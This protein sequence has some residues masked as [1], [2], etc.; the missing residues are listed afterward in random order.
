MKKLVIEKAAIAK[1]IAVIKEKAGE[2]TLYGVLTGDGHGGGLLELA[3]MLRDAGIT[4]FAVT[5][6][7]DAAALR[8]AGF[9]SEEL[10][11]L[12]SV[13]NREELET[14][15]DLNVVFTIGSSEAGMALN[16][17]AEGRATVVEA[18]IE[19]DTGMGLGG[20]LPE[21]PDKIFAI[22]E[23]L[24]NV[25]VSGIFTETRS[26]SEKMAEVQLAAFRAVLD[27]IH[28]K[29]FETGCVHAAGS[30]AL[31]HYGIT[32]MEA[33]RVG[34]ALLG[35]CRRTRDDKLKKV[36]YGEVSVEEIRWLPRGHTVGSERVTTLGKATRV[37]VLP[38]GYQNGF[39]VARSHGGG[40][41][42]AIGDWWARRKL[43]VTIGGQKARVIGHVGAT[44][45]VV[46]ITELK[47]AAG[48]VAIFDVDPLYAKGLVREYR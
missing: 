39:A 14:L 1:N 26:T 3:Q 46:N 21:E 4:R 22:Y 38:M 42:A 11:M 18:H 20:F 24:P 16:G 25:A 43:C 8:K 44:Q 9:T 36:G 32:G 33:A 15:I 47:C 37:A 13:M 31:L 41:F 5:E 7:E 23:S 28:A 12:R 45:T 40:L 30:Y 19:I 2:M 29:G 17:L 35:R 6:P 27:A 48:D 10:L 34:T